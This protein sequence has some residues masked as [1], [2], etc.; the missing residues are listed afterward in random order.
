[1]GTFVVILNSLSNLSLHICLLSARKLL[2]F[3]GAS[4]HTYL[5]C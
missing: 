5:Y 4:Y 2:P 3:S 1:M